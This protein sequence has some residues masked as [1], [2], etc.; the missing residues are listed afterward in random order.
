M[1]LV[2]L[3]ETEPLVPTYGK[4][5]VTITG[6]SDA[7]R[8]RHFCELQEE[9]RSAHRVVTDGAMPERLGPILR[10]S[11]VGMDAR[12]K[13]WGI[14]E[15]ILTER[16]VVR[17]EYH[18]RMTPD[19]E[20]KYPTQDSYIRE[21]TASWK[22]EVQLVVLIGHHLVL[23]NGPEIAD[24]ESSSWEHG[25]QLAWMYAPECDLLDQVQIRAGRAGGQSA[26]SGA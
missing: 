8:R 6:V 9:R 15:S 12:S 2:L 25:E 18:P 5:H 7:L 17:D 16:A 1:L 24:S 11:N 21:N 14:Y 13:L 26:I 10:T 23:E 20:A 22:A 19:D 4:E 3:V